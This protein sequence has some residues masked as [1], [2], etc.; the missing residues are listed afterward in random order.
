M[1]FRLTKEELRT[2]TQLIDDLNIAATAIDQAVAQY[3]LDVDHL[4]TPVELAVTKYNELVAKARDLCVQVAGRA[5]QD[6]GDKSEEWMET[7]KGLASQSWQESWDGIEL[8]DLDFQWP[9]ELEISIDDHADSL[10]D[11][12]EEADEV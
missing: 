3:N 12:P 6:L 5:E 2:R 9:D 8:D 10:K 4:R 1:P 11:L 7:E